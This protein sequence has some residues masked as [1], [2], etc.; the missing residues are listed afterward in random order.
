MTG[1]MNPDKIF[2][3]KDF[4]KSN[5][6]IDVHISIKE[7]IEIVSQEIY[8]AGAVEYSEAAVQSE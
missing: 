8:R 4:I 2:V 7:K 3:I 5:L 6:F 1:V